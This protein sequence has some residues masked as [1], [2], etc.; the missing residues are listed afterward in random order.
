MVDKRIRKYNKTEVTQ[1]LIKW[2]CYGPEH[3]QWKSLS[4]LDNCLKLVE[5]YEASVSGTSQPSQ[6]TVTSVNV[7]NL[8]TGVNAHTRFLSSMAGHGAHGV[9]FSIRELS[10]RKI[11][12]TFHGDDLKHYISRTGYLSSPNDLHFPVQQTIRRVRQRKKRQ[13]VF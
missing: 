3:N 5:K 7:G 4:A 6:G 9:S 12:G 13:A 10:G 2:L 8:G 1:F 11:S